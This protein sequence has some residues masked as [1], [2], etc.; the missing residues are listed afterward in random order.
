MKHVLKQA[1][2]FDAKTHD[3]VIYEKI[4]IR[5][6]FEQRLKLLSITP[7]VAVASPITL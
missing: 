1:V 5:P 2:I 6:L 4:P 3:V 7:G